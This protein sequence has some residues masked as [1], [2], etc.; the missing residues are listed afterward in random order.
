MFS[1]C[2]LDYLIKCLRQVYQETL[3]SN[4]CTN[5]YFV[6]V[7]RKFNKGNSLVNISRQ[8]AKMIA[9]YKSYL[10]HRSSL[11]TILRNL[12]QH[13]FSRAFSRDQFDNPFKRSKWLTF[14]YDG[15]KLSSQG[16][17]YPQDISQNIKKRFW[18]IFPH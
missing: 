3:I 17:L 1:F 15:I 12:G 16:L 7:Y 2:K 5:I 18:K 11:Y 8:F 13:T 14:L 4:Q 10:Y 6:M 9:N